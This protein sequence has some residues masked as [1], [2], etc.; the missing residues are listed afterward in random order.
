MNKKISVI[1]IAILILNL[2]ANCKP[3]NEKAKVT[4]PLDAKVVN[5]NLAKFKEEYSKVKDQGEIG[6]FL[7]LNTAIPE[8]LNSPDPNADKHMLAGKTLPLFFYMSPN[9]FLTYD[10]KLLFGKMFF[11]NAEEHLAY[12][13]VRFSII[14]LLDKK[15]IKLIEWLADNGIKPV[16]R[17]I[18]SLI[19]ATVNFSLPND[20]PG[21]FWIKSNEYWQRMLK[22][23]NPVYRLLALQY[24]GQ[25]EKN[26]GKA[27]Q[28]CSVALSEPNTIFHF[29]ALNY[30]MEFGR[31]ENISVIDKYIKNHENKSNDGTYV[32]AEGCP[33]IIEFA[34]DV[35]KHLQ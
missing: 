7:L 12:L 22:A 5:Q 3:T 33:N 9:E 21:S 14:E 27:L 2:L 6:L 17:R 8:T 11:Q 18:D 23:K 32:T 34:K 24:L 4:K 26:S 35:K 29:H 15:S 20:S 25:I 19:Y 16:Q 10:E 1:F 13:R 28:I 31:K 30:L